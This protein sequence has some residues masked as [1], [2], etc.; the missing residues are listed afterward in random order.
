MQAGKK[1]AHILLYFPNPRFWPSVCKSI[2]FVDSLGSPDYQFCRAIGYDDSRETVESF[3]VY[4]TH[5]NQPDKEQ[6][7]I[8]D[9]WG[10]DS[11]LKLSQRAHM[12]YHNRKIEMPDAVLD[13]LIWIDSIPKNKVITYRE[14]AYAACSS[15]WF[16]AASNP[17]VRAVLEEHNF[18]ARQLNSDTGEGVLV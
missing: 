17:I 15:A 16:K 4:M 18:T 12:R 6:Y 3:M 7:N 10:S 11:V 5:R 2:G 9:L 8:T 1:H 13:C 14:F